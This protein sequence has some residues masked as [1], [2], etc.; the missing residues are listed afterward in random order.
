MKDVGLD[1]DGF[2]D[3]SDTALDG[4]SQDFN[5]QHVSYLIRLPSVFFLPN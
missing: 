1:L 5:T 4:T 3:P 2:D